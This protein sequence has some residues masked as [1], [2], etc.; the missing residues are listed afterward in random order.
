MSYVWVVIAFFAIVMTH[1][2]CQ[3]LW[4]KCKKP[5]FE[6]SLEESRVITI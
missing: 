5:K 3:L 4:Y 6:K 2:V 1:F